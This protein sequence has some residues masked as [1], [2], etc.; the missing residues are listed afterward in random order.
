M[1]KKYDWYI[2]IDDY[3]SFKQYFPLN[4]IFC[5]TINNKK[6]CLIKTEKNTYAFDEKCPHN[7]AS[8]SLGFCSSQESVVCPLHR[9]H[10]DL[11]SG[12][13]LSGGA[14]NLTIYPLKVESNK[15]F[16]GFEI[17]DSAWWK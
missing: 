17:K 9:Y 13:A 2:L 5:Y 16:V 8:L 7:G 4:T 11:V 3:T 12:K 1:E 10:F 15:M 6:I 14:S